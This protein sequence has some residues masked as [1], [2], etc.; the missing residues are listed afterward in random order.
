MFPFSGWSLLSV[1]RVLTMPKSPLQ[2]HQS[3]LFNALDLLILSSNSHSLSMLNEWPLVHTKVLITSSAFLFY[4]QKHVFTH[5]WDLIF[6]Q[7][8]DEGHLYLWLWVHLRTPIHLCNA[9]SIRLKWVPNSLNSLGVFFSSC[10]KSE[11]TIQGRY[12]GLMHS[13]FLPVFCSATLSTRLILKV[14]SWL[15]NRSCS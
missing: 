6:G 2:L 8:F 11:V 3:L 15:Q 4:W 10:D 7:T 14:I 12:G 1:P 5:K 13:R 9:S